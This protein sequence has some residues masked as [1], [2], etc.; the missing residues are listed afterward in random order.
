MGLEHREAKDRLLP[1][2]WKGPLSQ[3]LVT[4]LL[5]VVPRCASGTSMQPAPVR[6]AVSPTLLPLSWC[7]LQR[8]LPSWSCWL[9]PTVSSCAELS[10]FCLCYPAPFLYCP[11]LRL[12][13][14]P[15]LPGVSLLYA[16]SAAQA[17]LPPGTVLA[18]LL[19]PGGPQPP[20]CSRN[21]AQVQCPP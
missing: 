19:P 17:L 3:G 8:G 13:P 18:M 1:Q 4:Y 16:A 15:S 5:A 6:L 7:R 2:L 20:L 21:A 12:P 11:W 14:S 10:Q 9:K